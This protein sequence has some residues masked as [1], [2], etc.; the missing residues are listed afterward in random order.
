M[1]TSLRV[2]DP[3]GLV[4]VGLLHFGESY[5]QGPYQVLTVK[6]RGKFPVLPSEGGA[7]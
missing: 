7:K 5:S 3:G 2:K 1:K 4:S 6:I